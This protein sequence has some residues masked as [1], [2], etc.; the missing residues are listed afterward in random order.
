MYF[1]VQY[2]HAIPCSH[3]VRGRDP[4]SPDW[5]RVPLCALH[6]ERVTLNYEGTWRVHLARWM[7]QHPWLAERVSNFLSGRA[8]VDV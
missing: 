8:L 6:H 4:A 5:P 7:E 3:P 1:P 2:H